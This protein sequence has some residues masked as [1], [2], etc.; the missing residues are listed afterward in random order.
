M[1]FFSIRR[2]VRH[3]A[4]RQVAFHRRQSLASK[5]GAEFVVGVA[6]EPCAKVLFGLAAGQVVA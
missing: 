2:S 5:L 3:A 4:G 6:A 1:L